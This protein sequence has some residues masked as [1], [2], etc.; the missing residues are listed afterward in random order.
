ME[1]KIRH[2][3]LQATGASTKPDVVKVGLLLNHIGD[4][5][6]EIFSNFKFLEACP[7]PDDEEYQLP[8]EKKDDFAS[9]IRKFDEF[10]HRR[11]PQ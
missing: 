10:F 8:A 9:V 7:D 1:I 4:D 2:F 11:D 3:F 6:L 5:G